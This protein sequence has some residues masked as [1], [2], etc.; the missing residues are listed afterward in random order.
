MIPGLADLTP[1]DDLGWR[2]VR[3]AVVPKPARR[4]VG[5]VSPV[6]KVRSLLDDE[7]Y[8]PLVEETVLAKARVAQ[9]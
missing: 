6:D 5:P 9:R 1:E 3:T 8:L 2:A 7:G 4:R